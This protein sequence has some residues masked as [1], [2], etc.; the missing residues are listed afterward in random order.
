M[1]RAGQATYRL[2]K[3]RWPN[4]RQITVVCGIGNNGGDGY[5]VARLA[6]QEGLDVSLLQLGDAARLTGDALTMATA[7]R[8]AGGVAAPFDGIPRGT[9][10]LVDAIFGTGLER[11]VTGSWAAAIERMNADPAP[12]LAVDIP[13]GLHS[14]TG[15]VMGIAVRA[16]AT[17][18]FIGLK[19]GLW[20]GNGPAYCGAVHFDA[21]QVP[22]SVYATQILASRRID[23]RRL[24]GLL[25][26]RQR[27]AHKGDFGHVLIVGGA[28]G[29]S[30]AAR[31]AG[32]A[33]LRAGAGL[34]S[35]ATDMAH[36]AILNSGR[37]EL[38]CHG[39]G[40]AAELEPLIR[41]AS[42]IAVGP[43]LGRG[44]WSRA[45]FECCLSARKLVVVDADAL[46]LLAELPHRM[47]HWIL[48]PHPG[49]ASR[50][51]GVGTEE[52]GSDRFA[53]AKWLQQRFGGVVVLKGAGTIVIG[54]SQRPPGVCSDGNPG[55]ASGGSGDALTGIIA[56][57]LAQGLDPQDA[58]E[59]GVCLHGAA[60]DRA[61]SG[62]E[63]GLLASDLIG[64]L[65]SLINK[66]VK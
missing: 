5:V 60:G 12:V 57:L 49:E 52:I 32:E 58:A 48:T 22:A 26:P 35:I 20:T 62:G 59:A 18:S 40:G 27:D 46:N 15:R 19:Q 44:D 66:G 37:P 43:G 41:R 6:R 21:L 34:V 30:G 1:E 11:D 3:E 7:Y 50:L 65:R 36:A 13:S 25:G 10:V 29:F 2:L 38:M 39:V 24:Q 61:A 16:S 53:A 47:D 64:V 28:P 56:A 51:L 17:M 8:E 54:P 33:A 42:V 63:C 23:W 55:M 45:L 14:D 4:V 31:L 9:D